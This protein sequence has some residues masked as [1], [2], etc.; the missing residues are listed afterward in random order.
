MKVPLQW[1]RFVLVAACLA[2]L[3]FT[4]SPDARV[5]HHDCEAWHVS[6]YAGTPWREVACTPDGT[7]TEPGRTDWI[8]IIPDPAEGWILFAHVRACT[9]YEC[10][11]WTARGY[12]ITPREP[13]EARRGSGHDPRRARNLR[14]FTESAA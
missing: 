4:P 6:T 14:D 2:L 10:T 3:I 9:L 1:K 11:D 8:F 5:T 7:L 12:E 13:I